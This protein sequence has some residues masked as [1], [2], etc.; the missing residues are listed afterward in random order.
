MTI[1]RGVEEWVDGGQVE[2]VKLKGRW[3]IRSYTEW[4][5]NCTEVDL[6]Q[7]VGWLREHRP[8]LIA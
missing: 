4:G 2:L 8:D 7:L 1:M 6:L 3:V 5:Y